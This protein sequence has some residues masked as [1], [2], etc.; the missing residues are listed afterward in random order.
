MYRSTIVEKDHIDINKKS[1]LTGQ[2]SVVT[3][4]TRSEWNCLGHTHSAEI[5]T[6]LPNKLQRTP[7]GNYGRLHK[8]TTVDA[9]RTT[10]QEDGDCRTLREGTWNQKCGQQ[11]SNTIGRRWRQQL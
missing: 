11:V 9:T 4:I 2:E 3:Q 5:M 6:V 1:N 7:W 8:T 10:R